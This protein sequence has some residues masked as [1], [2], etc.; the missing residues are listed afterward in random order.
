MKELLLTL[1]R[2]QCRDRVLEIK[3]VKNSEWMIWM[4]SCLTASP[5][6]SSSE[7]EDGDGMPWRSYGSVFVTHFIIQE[8]KKRDSNHLCY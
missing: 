2:L 5:S 7:D 6:H 3:M 1:S 8:I 4:R